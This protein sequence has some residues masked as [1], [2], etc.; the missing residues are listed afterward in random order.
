MEWLKTLAILLAA[1]ADD[2]IFHLFFC[3]CSLRN[4]AL[5]YRIAQQTQH[6]RN[7]KFFNNNF[8]E[9]IN[10]KNKKQLSAIEYIFDN[11]GIPND[12]E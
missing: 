9:K 11:V 8:N 7:K 3:E 6:V 5:Y 2:T 4:R 12:M 1:A 10:R